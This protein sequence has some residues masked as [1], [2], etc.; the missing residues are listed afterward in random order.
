MLLDLLIWQVLLRLL[1]QLV[2]Q[3]VVWVVGV[4]RRLLLGR[5]WLVL[6]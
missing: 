1:S 3:L 2:L 6:R 5:D 4:H